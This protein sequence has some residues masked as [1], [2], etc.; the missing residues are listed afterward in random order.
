M[1][2]RTSSSTPWITPFRNILKLEE[3]HGFDDN[4]VIGGLD[5]FTQRWAEAI[6]AHFP[7]SPESEVAKELLESNYSD[8]SSPQRRQWADQWLGL[9]EAVPTEETTTEIAAGGG[10]PVLPGREPAAAADGAPSVDG[11][12]PK[13]APKYRP[14][15]GGHAAPHCDGHEGEGESPRATP[16]RRRRTEDPSRDRGADM[17]R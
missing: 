17:T 6:G 12:A 4:A 2:S 14:P 3:T 16:D 11:P 5:R 7:D 9:L 1:P 10:K 8:M 15:P 13:R